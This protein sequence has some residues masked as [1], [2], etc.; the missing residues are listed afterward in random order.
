MTETAVA[1]W[2]IAATV[3]L[4]LGRWAVRALFAGAAAR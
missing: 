4:L 2:A 1:M 3:V